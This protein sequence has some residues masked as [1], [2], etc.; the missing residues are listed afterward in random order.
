MRNNESACGLSWYT[1][2]IECYLEFGSTGIPGRTPKYLMRYEAEN[3][4]STF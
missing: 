2:G 3:E 4:T 1:F